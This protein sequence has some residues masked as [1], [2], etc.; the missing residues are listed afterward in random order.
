MMPAAQCW[1][2]SLANSFTRVRATSVLLSIT[3]PG[4]VLGQIVQ[5]WNED[6][7]DLLD[8]EGVCSGALQSCFEVLTPEAF[9]SSNP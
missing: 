7:R 6:E 8:M 2:A 1:P 3:F 4:S 9:S 5:G